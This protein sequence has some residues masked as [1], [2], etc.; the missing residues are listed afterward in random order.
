MT[1]DLGATE[2]VGC[3][4]VLVQPSPSKTLTAI[5][6]RE[7]EV[8]KLVAEGLTN[9]AIAVRLKLSPETVKDHIHH[10]LQKSG[11]PNRA[12]IVAHL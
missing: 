10:I 8:A 12:A 5:S 11:L 1:L 4:L 7:L 9:K 6:P 2:V 3:P